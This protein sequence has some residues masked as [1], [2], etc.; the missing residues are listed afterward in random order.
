MQDNQKSSEYYIMDVMKLC[1]AFLILGGHYTSHYETPFI[2]KAFFSLSTLGVPFFFAC[3]G[4]LAARNAS[5][6]KQNEKPVKKQVKRLARIY[7]CWSIIYVTLQVSLFVK[8]N[9]VFEDI[10][11]YVHKCIVYS[12]YQTIWFLPALAIGLLATN[13]LCEKIGINKT[14]LLSI[15]IYIFCMFGFSYACFINDASFLG[16][17]YRIY[18]DVFISVRNGIFYAIPFVAIGWKIRDVEQKKCSLFS[19]NVLLLGVLV[20]SIMFYLAEALVLKKL[21][22]T[23]G[24]E[25]LIMHIIT[26]PVLLTV[27]IKIIGVANSIFIFFRKLS[28]LV[29][30]SQ[31]I[32]L[33]ALP[34]LIGGLEMIYSEKQWYIGLG[35][36][37]TLTTAFSVAFI[38]LSK[39]IKILNNFI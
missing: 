12:T 25:T 19:N 3:S 7:F 39:R 37:F 29:F 14:L 30:L 33:T 34:A 10:L 21:G 2:I 28:T 1:F 15:P 11:E 22:N 18:N 6:A 13:Y 31:R 5:R 32:F 8:N 9:A 16:N 38:Y 36:V 26:T 20:I 27:S 24:S 23:M 35:I 17:I 4:Y